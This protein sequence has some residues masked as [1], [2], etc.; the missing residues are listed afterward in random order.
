HNNEV[1]EDM[2]VRFGTQPARLVAHG[3]T[4]S[5]GIDPYPTLHGISDDGRFVLYGLWDLD[6]DSESDDPRGDLRR[7]DLLRDRVSEVASSP[8]DGLFH[9]AMNVSGRRIAF[10]TTSENMIDGFHDRNG[11]D[12]S[13][14]FAWFDKPPVAD[15]WAKITGALKL[16][17]DGSDSSDSDGEIVSYRWDFG[18]GKASGA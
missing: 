5:D 16:A 10:D 2:Y 3:E 14:V 8:L 11:E 18:D 15:A 1:G 9:I 12:G 4:A 7:M 17:F 13:D 6:A